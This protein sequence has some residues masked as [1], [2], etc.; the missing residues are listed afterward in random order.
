MKRSEQGRED[1]ELK[2]RLWITRELLA[3]VDRQRESA[4]GRTTTMITR[5]SI[6]MAAASVAGGATLTQKDPGVFLVAAA[7]LAAGA[8]VTGV[9]A[10]VPRGVGENGIEETQREMWNVN[11]PRAL[12]VFLSRKLETLRD[13][14]R[15]LDFRAWC[16]RIGFMLLTLSLVAIAAGIFEKT[17]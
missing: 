2:S 9:V 11:E 5:L 16:A 17:L 14:E 8:A 10:L 4:A 6:L 7:M 15:L 13:E 1:R 12:H 3:E